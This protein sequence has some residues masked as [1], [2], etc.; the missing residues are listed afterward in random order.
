M[1]TSGGGAGGYGASS[2]GG[3]IGTGTTTNQR[4]MQR[5]S[6]SRCCS[7]I[8]NYILRLRVSPEELDQR[9]KSREIDKFLEKDKHSFRR[10]VKHMV[11]ELWLI[12]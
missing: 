10:Q 1:A 6:C 4:S 12:H 8:F 9:Y 11:W 3:G 5:F 2:S 7:D